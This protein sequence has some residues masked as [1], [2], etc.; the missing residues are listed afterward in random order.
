MEYH[1]SLKRSKKG[2]LTF[3]DLLLA[4][5]AAVFLSILA[6]FFLQSSTAHILTA[7]TQQPTI[8][9]CNLA[10]DS[11]YG[12]YYVHTLATLTQ[13][14]LTQPSQYL[15]A[16]SGKAQSFSLDCGSSCSESYTF[17]SS[18]LSNSSSL[19]NDFI[20]Y[21]NSFSLS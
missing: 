21:F 10:L 17:L 2:Q 20:S 12:T 19:F 9:A 3:L 5:L 16:V 1:H 6:A 8:D 4:P 14:E 11:L 18:S 7:V 15:T 13:L